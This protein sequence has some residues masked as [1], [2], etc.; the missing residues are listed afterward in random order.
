LRVTAGN[1][2]LSDPFVNIIG[3][4]LLPATDW[5]LI[6]GQL[7]EINANWNDHIL[8]SGIINFSTCPF[9]TSSGSKFLYFL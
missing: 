6:S 7:D 8:L 9:M 4:L 3:H 1:T 2:N 5:K